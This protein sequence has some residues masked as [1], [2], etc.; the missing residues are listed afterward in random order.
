VDQTAGH[1]KTETEKPQNQKHHKN[2]PKHSYSPSIISATLKFG[3]LKI[4]SL[5]IILI[6]PFRMTFR[7]PGNVGRIA[8]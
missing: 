7:T 5:K 3:S 8:G 2:R 6:K 4:Q 1:M